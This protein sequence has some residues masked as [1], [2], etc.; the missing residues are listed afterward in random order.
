MDSIAVQIKRGY[1]GEGD[2]SVDRVSL[3]QVAFQY[4]S[5]SLLVHTSSRGAPGRNLGWYISKE[6]NPLSY[7]VLGE[8]R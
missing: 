7:F 2:V 6:M 5:C 3:R 4:S 1:R 8:R